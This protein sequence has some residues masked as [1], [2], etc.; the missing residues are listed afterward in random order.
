[1]TRKIAERTAIKNTDGEGDSS[2]DREGSA[3][4]WLMGGSWRG[5]VCGAPAD[6][7]GDIQAAQRRIDAQSVKTQL[8]RQRIA[9]S[10]L[11]QQIKD[12]QIARQNNEVVIRDLDIEIKKLQLMKLQR[13]L[14]AQGAFAPSFKPEN[15]PE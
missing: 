14:E 12:A 7:P 9:E 2:D 6:T 10:R 13:E 4:C 15:Y 1:M 8:D 3:G 5:P 11:N